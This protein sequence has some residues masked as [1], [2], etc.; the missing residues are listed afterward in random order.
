MTAAIIFGSIELPIMQYKPETNTDNVN[1]LQ[2]VTDL[3]Y[4]YLFSSLS[5]VCYVNCA[6]F[7]TIFYVI[8]F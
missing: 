4:K 6:S 2:I 8:I 7:I 5:C 1:I 3:K